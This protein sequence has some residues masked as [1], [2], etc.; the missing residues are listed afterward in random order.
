LIDVKDGVIRGYTS[1]QAINVYPG[2]LVVTM[3]NLE[4]RIYTAFNGVETTVTWPNQ[5][6]YQAVKKYF[7]DAG[8]SVMSISSNVP[9][10]AEFVYVETREQIQG[11]NEFVESL[12]RERRSWTGA[13][14]EESTVAVGRRTIQYEPN[15]LSY[16]SAMTNFNGNEAWPL[17]AMPRLSSE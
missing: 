11:L 3:P 14:G 13:A 2:W 5:D 9:T 16:I 4:M 17:Y 7:E 10:D 8:A 6:E 12:R 1:A 15:M